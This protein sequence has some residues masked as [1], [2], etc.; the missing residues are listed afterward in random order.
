MNALPVFV[1][2]YVKA[3]IKTYGDKVYT[4]FGD[5]NVPEYIVEYKSLAIISINSWP[6]YEEKYHLQVYFDNCAYK[7]VNKQMLDYLD[8]NLFKTYK[9]FFW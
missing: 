3:K 7:I 8:G 1:D 5:F 6:V 4:D 2:R 9:D